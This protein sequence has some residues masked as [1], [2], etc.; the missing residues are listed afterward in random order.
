MI[1]HIA[2]TAAAAFAAALALGGPARAAEDPST[3]DVLEPLTGGGA[4][5]GGTQKKN[6]EVTEKMINEEGGLHGKPIHF[7][8]HDDQTSPQTAVQLTTEI[9]ANHPPVVFGSTISGICNAMTPLMQNGPVHYCFSPSVRPKDGGYEFTSQIA[10]RD[11][12]HALLRFF[13]AKGWKRVALITTTDASGQDADKAISGLIKEPEFKD[14]QLVAQEYFNPA[15]V[16]ITAQIA[17]IAAQ[18]PNVVV[19]WATAAAGATV[20]RALVQAGLDLPTA[21]SGSNMTY[22]QMT[23]YAAFLPSQ[24]FFG[25]SA[26]AAHGSASTDLPEPV[27]AEQRKFFAAMS[28]AGLHTDASADIGWDTVRIVIAALNKLPPGASAEQLHDYLE[29]LQG[30]AGIDGIYNFARVKQRGLDLNNAIVVRW[31]R[32]AKDWTPVSKLT[33]IPL[34]Q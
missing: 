21:A 4:F 19:S 13:Q 2:C 7:V 16:G 5:L 31:D 32:A 15:D 27:L 12:Q 14:M 20:F 10:S 28:A 11:Q 1:A 6:I 26:W 3:F 30:Y 29:N 9:I 25:V 33:G 23:E 18:K 34:G 17:R 22:G 24:L 8:F